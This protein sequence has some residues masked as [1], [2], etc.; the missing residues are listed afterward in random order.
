[1]CVLYYELDVI[2]VDEL[3]VSLDIEKVFDVVKLL[4]KEVKEKDK[5]II[6]VI[7]DECLLKYCDWVVCICDG[8]LIE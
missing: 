2:L 7:Y 5:G 1:M 6:M 3:M 8:E 4:V